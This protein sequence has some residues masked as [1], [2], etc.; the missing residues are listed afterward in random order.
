MKPSMYNVLVVVSWGIF[1][2]KISGLVC[3]LVGLGA[4]YFTVRLFAGRELEKKSEDS[5]WGTWIVA[6]CWGFLLW[7]LAD[8]LP[9]YWS[10]L[11]PLFGVWVLFCAS[12]F[13][14]AREPEDKPE[15]L[16][17]PNINRGQ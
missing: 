4:L 17:S 7:K 9:Q 15:D 13:W 3:G 14:T 10:Q 6:L 16:S 1:F 8:Y 5:L 12:R 2:A 11:S